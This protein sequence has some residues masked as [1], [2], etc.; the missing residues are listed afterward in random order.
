MRDTEGHDVIARSVQYSPIHNK[1]DAPVAY[2]DDDQ[3]P[4]RMEED[5]TS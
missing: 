1:L 4:C 3:N 5:L 2:S